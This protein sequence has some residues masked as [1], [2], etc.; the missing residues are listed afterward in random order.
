MKIDRAYDCSNHQLLTTLAVLST[1]FLCGVGLRS[2]HRSVSYPTIFMPLLHRWIHLAKLVIIVAYR[3]HIW[4]KSIDN[5]SC[6]SL[7]SIFY[8]YEATVGSYH[9]VLVSNQQQSQ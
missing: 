8:H 4:V 7:D 1:N 9:L 6:S 3:I 2:I 5:F